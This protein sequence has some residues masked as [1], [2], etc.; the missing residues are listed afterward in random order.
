MNKIPKFKNDLKLSMMAYL[1]K[2][3]DVKAK[4]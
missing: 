1:C 2:C 3:R 4:E